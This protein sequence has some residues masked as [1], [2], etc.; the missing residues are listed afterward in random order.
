MNE[1][2]I[3]EK[4]NAALHEPSPPTSLVENTVARVRTLERGLAA[5]RRLRDGQ[6]PPEEQRVSLLAD[7]VM[8]RLARSGTIPLGADVEALK[9]Q[10][11]ANKRFT[12]I[13]RRDPGAF[14]AAWDSGKSLGELLRGKESTVKKTPQNR[15]PTVGPK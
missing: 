8:G 14:L 1:Q 5:E 13:A 4:L 9:G 11:M 6:A 2:Q 15:G 12:E 3:K 10:I 7:S